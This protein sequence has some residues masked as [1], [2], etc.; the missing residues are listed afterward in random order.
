MPV[1]VVLAVAGLALL[2][3]AADQLVVGAARLAAGLGVSPVVVGVVVIG[4]GT[5]A[6]EFVVAGLAAARGDSGLALANLV[7]SNI[8]NVTLILGVAALVAPVTVRSSIPRREAPLAVAAVTLFAGFALV[9]LGRG[10]GV[11]LSVAS[12]AALV[13]LVRLTHVGAADPMPAEVDDFLA[14]V[15]ADTEQAAAQPADRRPTSAGGPPGTHLGREALRAVLGLAGT[16]LGAQLLVANAATAAQRLGVPQT[17]VGFTLVALGTSL[18]ELVTAV[19]AQRRRNA[20][21][22]VGNLLG[23]N[24]FNSLTGGAIVGLADRSPAHIGYPVLA[25]MVAVILLTWLVLYRRY[26]VSRTEAALLLVAYLLT[27]PL[28]S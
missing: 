8:I 3:V 1:L 7:G 12:V 4:V 22:L 28:I 17:V 20:D 19:Q 24:L 26:R 10:A 13:V 16:L 2:T 18:P 5:S 11:V 23:S 14:D 25:A 21:L 27:L 15:G 6:P 9:G